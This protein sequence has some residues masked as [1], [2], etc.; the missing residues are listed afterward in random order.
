MNAQ[1]A[2]IPTISS[3]ILPALPPALIIM[4]IIPTY[5][6]KSAYNVAK[7]AENAL[8]FIQILVHRAY[9]PL[10][11]LITLNAFNIARLDSWQKIKF[12]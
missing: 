9:P 2:I 3:L 10:I 6:P 1:H 7:I 4:T 5:N 8:T 11:F 12:V